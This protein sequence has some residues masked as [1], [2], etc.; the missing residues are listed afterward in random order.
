[1][2]Q[3]T[4]K[5]SAMTRCGVMAVVLGLGSLAASAQTFIHEG[6]VY[7]ASG[8]KLTAQSA[9]TKPEN[10]EA[11][12]TYA[13]D[14][15]VPYEISYNGKDYVV[16]S[17]AGV[18]KGMPE[19][20]SIEIADGVTTIS[21]G[22]FQG[23]SA[24]VSVKL[25]ADL[26]T[27]NGD[28]F[29]GCKS[30]KEITFPGEVKEISSNQLKGCVSLEKITFE[31]GETPLELSS[32]VFSDGIN[33]L[34]NLTEV[35]LN[36]QIG[37]KF[38]AMDAKPFRGSKYLTTVTIG[39][40]TQS[41][42]TS[43]FENC[44]ALKNV[45]IAETVTSLGTNVFAGSGIEEITLPAAIT[46]VTSSTFQGCKSLK[47]VVLGPEV[48]A[49]QDMAFYNSTVSEVALP[50]TVKTI[51]QMAFSG[52]NLSGTL[53]LPAAL[54]SV[55][56]QAFANNTGITSVT[57]P[58][59]VATVNDGAF[60]GCTGISKFNLA[61]GNETLTVV[62][63]GK[64]LLV[65]GGKTIKAVAPASDLA[66]LT[67]N[68]EVISPYAAYNAAGVK[69]I[70][71]PLCEN[72]GDYAVAGT[73]IEKLTVQGIVGRYVAA[74]CANLKEITIEGKE[75][76]FG[77]VANNPALTSVNVIDKLTTVKQD[78]FLNCTSL[79]SL[80]LGSILAIIEA[81]AFK[82]SG[83]KN[84]TVT[85]ANPA[86]MAD[87]VFTEDMDIT[88]NVP[89]DLV[90]VY[91][92]AAGWSLLNIAGDA[93]LASGA[94]DMGMPNGLY[95]AGTDGHLHAV[96]AD[97][98][99]DSYDVGGVPHTFQLAQFKNRI[100]G[101][102]AGQKFVY[103]AT[104]DVDGDGKLFYISKVGGETFQ[105]VVLDNTGN[106]AYKDPF[107]LYVYGDTL[108]V[109]DRNVCIRKIP[110]DAIA[111][112]QNYPSWVENNW[113]GFYGQPWTYGCI[114]CGWAIT[115][116]EKPNGD[117]EPVY[118]VGM[119]YN[120]NGLY[121]FKEEHVGTSSKVGDKPDDGTFLVSLAPIY[122]TFNID[123]ENGHIYLYI[124]KLNDKN[125]LA[126][127]YRINIEDLED[128][129]DPS[130]FSKLNP[131]LI[132]GAPVFYEGS[133]TNEHV[134]ISQLS[135]DEN[136]EY[137]YWCYRAPTAADIENVEKGT[138]GHYAWAENYDANNPLHRSGIKRIKLGEDS[139]EVELVVEGVEGYGVVPVNYEGS[140]KPDIDSVKDV[141][142]VNNTLSYNNGALTCA[143]DATVYVYN[144][145][146]VIVA[147]ANV[148]AGEAYDVNHLEAGVYVAADGTSVVK[149]VK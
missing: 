74:N 117:P 96:Y 52:T 75:V 53:E 127:L 21:R 44:T 47:R 82:G 101:A 85:A 137:M 50:A 40:S 118:W 73:G 22:C 65:N 39:G 45:T 114:K 64:V 57:F 138:E 8:N 51:G 93:N 113:M 10:G 38:T 94:S 88:V 103:S 16:T 36:R 129:P 3:S 136:H 24:L 97:G 13:G 109:N 69:T 42:P 95:Y 37:E 104:G 15:K 84:I 143:T 41:I 126:G 139:P 54:T 59:G 60:M 123:E 58:A 32:G 7:K 100:Y 61:G 148:K 17:I 35:V 6:V 112:P 63:D 147:A 115:Q 26:L 56:L 2:K 1:M 99:S 135:F 81:D 18:F 122:T 30:L 133:S 120:G 91:K 125:Y 67:G 79:E 28:M 71:L 5:L 128:N 111:L 87:G 149:F 49:I 83:L 33:S 92:N 23:D 90:D 14:I 124:E 19:L 140:T 110:A 48:T 31:A 43:Y 72:W 62:E 116:G 132:D 98:Q 20:T 27:L 11:P 134:G 80:N 46:T 86:A 108:Y 131:I 89:V 4:L 68:Y 105:A 102:S 66:S 76:P 9:T 29:N 141:V 121:R 55:G 142:V 107:G 144:A 130:D 25:P 78:A 145:A 106:N 146:G 12:G 70:E 119:K 77:I 34:P